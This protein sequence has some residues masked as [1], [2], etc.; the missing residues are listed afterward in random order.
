M[1]SAMPLFA[2][3]VAAGTF[4]ALK[5]AFWLGGGALLFF[6]L[7]SAFP[8]KEFR[9]LIPVFPWF[10]AALFCLVDLRARR[11]RQAAS[12]VLVGVAVHSALVHRGLSF[13]QLGA[14]PDRPSA[15]AYNDNGGLNRL[16][17]AAYALPDLCGLRIDETH[18]AWTGGYSYLHREV[19][20][21]H[22]GQSPIESGYFNYAI[23]RDDTGQAVAREGPL[24]LIKVG[25]ERCQKDP[26]YK[27][28]LP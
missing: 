23:E 5:K 10:F 9:F 15:S 13:G 4:L 27:W 7:H 1:A 26:A 3:L 8:H 28:N 12:L 14:Y 16:L 24:A 20:L 22:L 21:Y 2:L 18:L 11:L 17:I 6:G 25:S 19:P